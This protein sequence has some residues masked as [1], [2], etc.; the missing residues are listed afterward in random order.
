MSC[1]C[2]TKNLCLVGI[3]LTFGN[4][5]V[6]FDFRFDKGAIVGIPLFCRRFLRVLCFQG[7]HFFHRMT[8]L[9]LAFLG[10]PI[11]SSEVFLSPFYFWGASFFIGCLF[12]PP[13]FLE[14]PFFV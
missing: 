6:L 4:M 7:Y 1:R 14:V 12:E 10:V 9:A 2:G 5:M 13:V 8:F 3:T 11:F